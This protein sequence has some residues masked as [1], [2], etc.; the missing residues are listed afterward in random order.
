MFTRPLFKH[1]TSALIATVVLTS[2]VLAQNAEIEAWMKQLWAETQDFEPATPVEIRWTSASEGVSAEILAQWKK[3]VEGKPE[4]PRRLEIPAHERRLRDGPDKANFVLL[5][6][7][8][9]LWRQSEDHPYNPTI[10]YSDAAFDGRVC[11]YLYRESLSLW[12]GRDKDASQPA[13]RRQIIMQSVRGF[14][15]QSLWLVAGLGK[16][17]SVLATSLDQDRWTSQ[18]QSSSGWRAVITGTWDGSRHLPAVN[19]V[20]MS[21]PGNEKPTITVKVSKHLYDEVLGKVVAGRLET[22]TS[23]SPLITTDYLGARKVSRADVAAAAAPPDPLGA[24]LVRGQLTLKRVNDYTGS[25]A[26]LKVND[27]TPDW[28][29]RPL[30]VVPRETSW[31]RWFGWS[32]AAAILATIIVMRVRAS[33]RA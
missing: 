2:P 15:S 4:H 5:Y 13:E 27:G 16:P 7:D 10:M 22:T 19:R 28:S 29:Q 12:N 26:V 31:R 25:M 23:S 24:D 6:A 3:E 33:R 30:G 9:S 20:E 21:A 32:A 11:W 17:D 14:L 18:V 1:T 8:A